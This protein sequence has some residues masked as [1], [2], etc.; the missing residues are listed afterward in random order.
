[1]AEKN[2][3]IIEEALLDFKKIE[4]ALKA[5]SK[6]ILRSI[7]KEEIQGYMK[8]S[9]PGEDK[10][11]DEEEVGDEDEAPTGLPTKPNKDGSE[12]KPETG[13]E[14]PIETGDDGDEIGGGD[15]LPLDLDMTGASDEDV[16]A[17]YKKLSGSDEIEVVSNK[18]VKITDPQSGNQYVVKLGGGGV[19]SELPAE[20][21]EEPE[22]GDELEIGDEDGEAVDTKDK[23]ED[24][25]GIGESIVYEIELQEDID[26]GDGHDTEVKNTTAPNTGDIESQKSPE[27]PESGD[28]LDGGF[29]EDQKFADD[30]GTNVMGEG[31]KE[32]DEKIQVGKGNTIANAK[33]AKTGAPVGA[34][35]KSNQMN[36]ESITAKYNALVKESNQL[37]L[38]NIEFR[39]SLKKFREMLSE[40]VIF[41]S[42]LA[43]VVKL[44]CEHATTKDEK[45]VIVGRFDNT[46]S[47]IKE[48][49]NLYRLIASELSSKKTVTESV[50]GKINREA[51]SSK[52]QI[53]ESTAYVDASTKRINDLIK[54]VENR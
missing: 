25:D 21:K 15:E 28:N 37:K 53:T 8:E 41:N 16:I 31:E 47:S 5:N 48:S 20:P 39:D 51:G 3:T 19:T 42:N 12:V 44:F 17:V 38:E 34:G 6:E 45:K 14:L 23:E 22:F 18:E 32:I 11:Y 52:A 30:K 27:D 13:G 40:T 7:M 29:D 26:R 36:T 50:E 4:D 49:K 1:M 43:H 54:R 46:V 24:E 10:D 9:I 35:G 2:Q 33:T